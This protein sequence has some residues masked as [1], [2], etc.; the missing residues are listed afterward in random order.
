MERIMRDFNQIKMSHRW[1]VGDD[2]ECP[3][4]NRQEE[5]DVECWVS[6]DECDVDTDTDTEE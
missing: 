3:S 4:C 6:D 1:N 5:S 2:C